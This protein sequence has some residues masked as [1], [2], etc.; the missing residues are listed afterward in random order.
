MQE[1]NEAKLN[2]LQLVFIECGLCFSQFPSFYLETS[3]DL[4]NVNPAQY[5]GPQ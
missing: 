1:S 4:Y 2:H 3:T 5:K